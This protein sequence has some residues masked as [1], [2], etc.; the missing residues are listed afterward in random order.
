MITCPKGTICLTHVNFF[1]GAII[2][3]LGL[4]IV[5]RDTYKKI[6]DEITDMRNDIEDTR[7]EV[8]EDKL[9]NK[10]SN[11]INNA[12]EEKIG[13]QSNPVMQPQIPAPP[14]MQE[15]PA[16]KRMPIN[17]ETR[18][19]GGEYQQIGILTKESIVD[20]DVVPGNNTD[21]VILPLFGRPVY[22]G[23]Q[24][25]NYYTATDKFH[26]VRVP[27][28]INGENCTDRR[29]CKELQNNDTVN[30]PGYNS[31]FRVQIYELDYPRYIPYVN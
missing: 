18:P 31:V 15:P 10:I 5:N 27:L 9:E 29:G 6:H 4:Y 21:T 7:E 2:I 26:Q 30:V 23:S 3:L 11:K 28:S 22:R 17:I 14:L 20:E 12:L 19:S 25:Y 24:M 8:I 13:V 1:G 16:M